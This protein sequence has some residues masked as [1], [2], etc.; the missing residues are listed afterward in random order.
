MQPLVFQGAWL[1]THTGNCSALVESTETEVWVL[2]K[3]LISLII[4][5]VGRLPRPSFF[6]NSKSYPTFNHS[7]DEFPVQLQLQLL[8]STSQNI[9][10]LEIFSDFK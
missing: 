3:A 2:L 10:N 7:W 5:F 6:Y 9:P 8:N 4:I 1:S